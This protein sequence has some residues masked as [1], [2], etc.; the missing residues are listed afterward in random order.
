MQDIQDATWT[1][2]GRKTHGA[3]PDSDRINQL[4]TSP[5]VMTPDLM[6][7]VMSIDLNERKQWPVKGRKLGSRRL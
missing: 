6:T 4:N 3:S 2:V 1:E 7:T 5:P